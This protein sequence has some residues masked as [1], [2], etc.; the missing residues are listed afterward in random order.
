M[1]QPFVITGNVE[2]AGDELLEGRVEAYDRD[3]PSLERLG[4]TPQLLGQSPLEGERHQFRIEFTDEQFRIRGE[5]D[6]SL[7]RRTG[8]ISPDLSFR[9]FDATGQELKIARVVAQN[10]EYRSEQII[11]NV[12]P[13]LESVVIALEPIPE[14]GNSEYERLVAAITPVIRNLLLADLT[15][16]DVVFLLNELGFEQQLD[17]QKKIEWLRR[18]ALLARQTDLPIEA[19]YVVSQ[20]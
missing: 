13:N 3:L 7:L 18:S 10:R 14:L 12:P 19:F 17:N 4:A 15:E 11:F 9:V 2:F 20:K 8:K 16:E 6:T 5:G 1:P